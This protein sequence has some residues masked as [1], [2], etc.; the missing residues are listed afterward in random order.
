VLPLNK[1]MD[2]EA[3]TGRGKLGSRRDAEKE[4]QT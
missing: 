2:K 3:G 4:G 1:R